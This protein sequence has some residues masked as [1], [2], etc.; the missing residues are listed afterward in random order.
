MTTQCFNA[1][2]GLVDYGDLRASEAISAGEVLF[3]DGSS[4][5][6]IADDAV[7]FTAQFRVPWGIARADAA[8]AAP[9]SMY[10]PGGLAWVLAGTGG[11]VTGEGCVAE[12][13]TG[14]ALGLKSS[15]A[16]QVP[17]P[18]TGTWCLGTVQI[19]AAAGDMALID[20][21]PRMYGEEF[22]VYETVNEGAGVARGQILTQDTAEVVFP[23]AANQAAV[24]LLTPFGIV[25]D[26]TAADGATLTIATGGIVPVLAGANTLVIGDFLAAEDA[27]PGSVIGETNITIADGDWYFGPC[28]IGALTTALG[29]AMFHPWQQQL[30]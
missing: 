19:G 22:V 5:P 29:A 17:L 12:A 27:T 24:Q 13:A 23:D 15:G 1:R 25:L 30:A 6:T 8:D 26:T 16:D 21:R 10:R 11:L 7:Q 3:L 9:V 18:Y 28:I 20:F 4:Q 14:R 2:Y